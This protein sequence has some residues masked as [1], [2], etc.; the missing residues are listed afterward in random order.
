MLRAS[1][2][3]P[4]I[5]LFFKASFPTLTTP[6]RVFFFSPFP[7][8]ACASPKPRSAFYLESV[9]FCASVPR[10]QAAAVV[11]AVAA[12]PAAQLPRPP[13]SCRRTKRSKEGGVQTRGPKCAHLSQQKVRGTFRI[14]FY[15]LLSLSFLYSASASLGRRAD[16]YLFSPAS[17]LSPSLGT[18]VLRCL[19]GSA[20]PSLVSGAPVRPRLYPLHRVKMRS[21]L[22]QACRRRGKCLNQTQRQVGSRRTRDKEPPFSL[23]RG[24]V[25]LGG[26][27]RGLRERRA[28]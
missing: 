3:F 13:R 5:L 14:Q 2:L 6:I 20:A 4:R 8:P 18:L 9:I 1:S 26:G 12:F 7:L 11:S 17:P 28:Q 16:R 15:P 19:A 10:E 21:R 23:W 22:Q 25:W 27:G 24:L